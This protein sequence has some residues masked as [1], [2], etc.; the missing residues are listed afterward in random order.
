M[1]ANCFHLIKH[2]SLR[3]IFA[4]FL[5]SS[6]GYVNAGEDTGTPLEW[7][8]VITSKY[9]EITQNDKG[10]YVLTLN[11]AH[12]EQVMAFS[13]RPNR[14]VK[15]ISPKEFKGLWGD[16]MNS[17]DHK[18]PNAIAVFGQEKIAMRLDSI[19]VQKDKTSFIVNSDDDTLHTVKMD[20]VAL[21]V[22]SS[23]YLPGTRCI[24]P[25]TIIQELEQL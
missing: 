5:M 16:G 13:D 17:F 6:I 2:A 1:I 14:K 8:F 24:Y 10:Q 15:L 25:K 7:L 12:V 22:D 11:H 4:L 18:P 3:L 9:G 19:S 21:F 20:G 23:C